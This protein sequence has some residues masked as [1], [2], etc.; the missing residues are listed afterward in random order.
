MA[1]QSLSNRYAMAPQTL[2]NCYAIAPQS[3]SNC[4]A[5]APQTLIN[6]YAIA[7]QSLSNCYAMAPQTLS[8]CYSTSRH[9]HDCI[10]PVWPPINLSPPTH[11]K[12]TRTYHH[13][14][15]SIATHCKK[16]T[17]TQHVTRHYTEPINHLQQRH[18]PLSF[19]SSSPPHHVS[20]LAT[21]LTGHN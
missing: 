3:L 7:P 2:I 21:R 9:H 12:N 4:Y 1:P 8:N 14:N 5:M 18:H 6:C 17:P 20:L 11:R 19:S 15:Q 16:K 13:R 10:S